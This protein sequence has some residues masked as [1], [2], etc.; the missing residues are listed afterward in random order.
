MSHSNICLAIIKLN[1]YQMNSNLNWCRSHSYLSLI[2]Y[3]SLHYRFERCHR[4]YKLQNNY[5]ENTKSIEKE[6]FNENMYGLSLFLD[7]N[8]KVQHFS[9][10]LALAPA[11]CF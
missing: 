1:Q 3:I 4:D 8:L 6:R 2:S 9:R 10:Y 7:D 11:V 5:I